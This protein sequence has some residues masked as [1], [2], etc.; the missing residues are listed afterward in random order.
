MKS[1][2]ITTLLAATAVAAPEFKTTTK[3]A[4][5]TPP[6]CDFDPVKGEYIC[7]EAANPW[8]V[9]DDYLHSLRRADDPSTADVNTS[10]DAGAVDISMSADAPATD[11]GKCQSDWE[12]CL[13][14]WDC[15]FYNCGPACHCQ[16]AKNDPSCATCPEQECHA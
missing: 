6:I 12:K 3:D 4:T 8:D 5:P 2:I 7:P 14:H 10:P 11:C 15:W 9:S 1:I 13:T 16:V